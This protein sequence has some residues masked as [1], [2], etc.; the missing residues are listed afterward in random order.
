M[1]AI[2]VILA[3][4]VVLVLV[5]AIDDSISGEESLIDKVVNGGLA[6]WDWLLWPIIG[7][8][9]SLFSWL[10]G[11]ASGGIPDVDIN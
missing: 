5:D 10:W 3:V 2:Q 7:A 11:L 1:A 4:G 6:L 9:G 8:I